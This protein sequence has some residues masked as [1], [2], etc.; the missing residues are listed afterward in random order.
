MTLLPL[1]GELR[2]LYTKGICFV[3]QSLMHGGDAQDIATQRS[4][5]IQDDCSSD[6]F[7]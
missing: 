1:E 5:K 7:Y 2:F 4:G 3:R 6:R